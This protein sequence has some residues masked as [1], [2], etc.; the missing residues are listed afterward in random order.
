M[1]VVKG[2]LLGAAVGASFALGGYVVKWWIQNEKA[3]GD[4]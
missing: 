1:N 4:A 3:D 2:T